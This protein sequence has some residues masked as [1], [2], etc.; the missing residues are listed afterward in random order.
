MIWAGVVGVAY[1]S[2][3]GVCT[4]VAVCAGYNIPSY[5]S[6]KTVS[7]RAKHGKRNRLRNKGFIPHSWE[8]SIMDDIHILSTSTSLKF[9]N[10]GKQQ[11]LNSFID[12]YRR[13]MSFFTDILWEMPHKDIPSLLPREITSRFDTRLAARAVQSAA[14]QAS[15]VVRGARTKQSKILHQIAKFKKDGKYRK[16]RKLQQKFDK[17]L[18]GKPKIENIQP[19]LDSRF[20]SV[21]FGKGGTF[22]GWLTLSSLAK[23]GS[24]MT[25]VIHLPFRKTVHFNRML[26]RGKIKPGARISADKATFMFDIPVAKPRTE[27]K[28]IGLDMGAVKVF[29][30]GDGQ[31]SQDDIHGWNLDRI[32]KR[33]SRKTKG[34]KAFGKVQRHRKNHIGWC[35]NQVDFSGVKRLNIERIRDLRRGRKCS[36]YLSHW[37]Y[38]DIVEKLGRLSRESGVLIREVNPTYTSQRCSECGWTRKANRNGR[39]F[40]CTQCGFSC[41]ADL[42][43]SVNIGLDLREI[44][45]RERLKNPNRK[46]FWWGAEGQEC[47]VPAVH[48]AVQE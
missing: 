46:G 9:A 4:L 38:T 18:V 21:S 15:G 8:Q 43:A 34:S 44:T 1:F 5:I 25:S 41:D 28:V 32:Q 40:V 27:G 3:D 6:W 14:K 20:V 37:T 13:A 36:R 2:R 31:Q 47:I 39:L 17:T 7:K 30:L 11:H 22:D 12:E 26:E 29:S 16:A 10:R 48:E 42:N 45:T 23:R 19:E 35:L 24:G 33:M